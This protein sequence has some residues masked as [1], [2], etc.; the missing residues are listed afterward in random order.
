MWRN[1][2]TGDFNGDGKDDLLW[3]NQ[4]TGQNA[5][6]G[7]A[8]DAQSL[9]IDPVGDYNADGKADVAWRNAVTGSSVIWS[10]GN[11]A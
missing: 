11:S 4:S 9:A 6:W 8:S 5:I 3:R 10:A 1:T 2:A 7:Q